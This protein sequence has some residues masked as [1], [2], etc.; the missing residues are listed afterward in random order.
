MQ[1]NYVWAKAFGS[2]RLTLRRDRI[3]DLGV[4]APHAFKMNWVYELPIGRGRAWLADMNPV[5]DRFIGGW[6]FYGVGRVQSG[7]LHDFGNVR[8]IGMTPEDLQAAYQLRFD[9]ANRIVYALP[10]DI[11]TN[12]IA[13]FNTS[14]T[15]STGYSSTYG[16]PTGRYVAPANTA[17]CIQVVSGDCAPR[18]YYVRGTPFIN[19]DLSLVKR[20]R[21]TESKNFEIRGEFLNAFNNINFDYV[22]CASSSQSCGQVDSTLSG[23]RLVQI[24]LRLNF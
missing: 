8:L 17:D 13:A 15:S 5:I 24:V 1:A 12:T 14:A 2:T 20:V 6:D 23:G 10:D 16:A 18:H 21:F 11:I 9:D 22:T 7:D 4:T 3:K 19:F